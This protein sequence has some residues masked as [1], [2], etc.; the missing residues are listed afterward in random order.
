ME[1]DVNLVLLIKSNCRSNIVNPVLGLWRRIMS[2]FGRE[3]CM[4]C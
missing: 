1:V 4:R 3:E 2:R